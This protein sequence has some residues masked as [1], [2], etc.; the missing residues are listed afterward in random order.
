MSGGQS[1]VIQVDSL[2][3]E[4]GLLGS[5]LL[6]PS[7]A[8]DI[9]GAVEPAYFDDPQLRAIY[10]TARALF[11]EGEPVTTHTVVVRVAQVARGRS[12]LERFGAGAT[13]ARV[14]PLANHVPS[15]AN[16]TFYAEEL[17]A[18]TGRRRLS[19]HIVQAQ[20]AL[21][22]GDSLA[23]V[24]SKMAAFAQTLEPPA[25]RQIQG[26]ALA[27]EGV[28][29]VERMLGPVD[30]AIPVGIRGVD[31]RLCGGLLPTHL[32]L[33]AARPGMGKSSL[34]RQMVLAAGERGQPVLMFSL[35]VARDELVGMMILSESGLILA[36]IKARLDARR[37]RGE[38]DVVMADVL[39]AD[40]A[41]HYEDAVAWVTHAMEAGPIIVDDTPA[42][43][44]EQV[45]A[46][47]HSVARKHGPPFIVIDY[48]QLMDIRALSK[49]AP[50]EERVGAISKG[51]KTLA[52]ELDASVLAL[53]Q[54]N[55][56]CEKRQDKRPIKS[57]LR[58]SGNLE[59]DA[60]RI[61]F[62]HRPHVYDDTQPRTLAEVIVAKNRQGSCGVEEAHWSGGEMRFAEPRWD[63]GL[64]VA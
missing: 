9:F 18:R 21:S 41:S 4:E 56:D 14:L 23:V 7:V 51:L 29:Y 16:W 54:L 46:S 13:A 10:T 61:F 62:L 53:C 24:S 50:R 20:E 5:L 32:S 49:R 39:S 43:T 60:D 31:A 6:D 3:L 48:L 8:P 19:A 37:A 2:A 33:L 38:E 34:A 22:R 27:E 45:R 47:A 1:Q 11:E 26:R 12:E 59:Q 35:E 17:R 55:R 57:D 44:L 42:A 30:H 52:K 40:E 36:T 28:S 15:S 63:E 58:E 64:E 25:P